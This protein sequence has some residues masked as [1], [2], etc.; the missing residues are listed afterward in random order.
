MKKVMK[1]RIT[2]CIVIL[3]GFVAI[4]LGAYQARAAT[5]CPAFCHASTTN[6]NHPW[7]TPAGLPTCRGVELVDCESRSCRRCEGSFEDPVRVCIAVTSGTNP[8]TLVGG[9]AECGDKY[10]R[11]CEVEGGY[12]DC[13]SSGGDDDG[14]CQFQTCLPPS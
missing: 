12:C 14:N 13:P 4:L 3:V 2:P 10:K 6:C 11:V 1:N 7:K 9:T 5:I 8:C